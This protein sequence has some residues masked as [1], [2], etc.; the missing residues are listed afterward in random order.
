MMIWWPFTV[1]Y[2]IYCKLFDFRYA[3]ELSISIKN[4]QNKSNGN[5]SVH[6]GI[7]FICHNWRLSEI[8]QHYLSSIPIHTEFKR[9]RC[10]SKNR[11]FD[12]LRN[13]LCKRSTLLHKQRYFH[14]TK[15]TDCPSIAIFF[16]QWSSQ[17]ILYKI[18][19]Y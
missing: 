15:N 4:I 5:Q 18:K 16:Q 11:K 13:N 3:A 12:S 6:F 2:I 10:Q 1:T 9:T 14:E 8:E 19:H 7:G 17:L